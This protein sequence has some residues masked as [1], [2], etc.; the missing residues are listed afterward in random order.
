MN[1]FSSLNGSYFCSVSIFDIRKDQA[2]SNEE[3]CEIV[4]ETFVNHFEDAR[5]DHKRSVEEFIDK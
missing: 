5:D 1:I 2:Q 4:V 3:G